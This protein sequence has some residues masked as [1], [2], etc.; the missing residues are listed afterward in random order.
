MKRY[1]NNRP[2]FRF[3]FVVF[4]VQYINFLCIIFKVFLN[5]YHIKYML[6]LLFLGFVILSL[7]R[8]DKNVHA[9]SQQILLCLPSAVHQHCSGPGILYLAFISLLPPTVLMTFIFFGC[10]TICF[11]CFG[12]RY[13]CWVFCILSDALFIFL[14]IKT[15]ET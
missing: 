15:Q 6:L 3:I 1:S 4:I 12:L 14:Y 13:I 8:N 11:I 5:T 2:I 10:I 9:S 7:R